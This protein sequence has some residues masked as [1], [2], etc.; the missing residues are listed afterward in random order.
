MNIV[1]QSKTTLCKNHSFLL[2]G[3]ISYILNQVSAFFSHCYQTCTISSMTDTGGHKRT[4]LPWRVS[5][6]WQQKSPSVL[7]HH[8]QFYLSTTNCSMNRKV[9]VIPYLKGQSSNPLLVLNCL[10]SSSFA[11][12]KASSVGTCTSTHSCFIT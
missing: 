1:C 11:G 5:C 9:S 2:L 3:T 6:Y 10:I 7:T 4:N 8:L 12:H